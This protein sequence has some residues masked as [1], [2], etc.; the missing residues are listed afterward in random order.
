MQSSA[1]QLVQALR[2]ALKDNDRLRREHRELA[3][4]VREPI[5]VV[6]MACRYPGGVTSPAELWQLVGRGGD[7]ITPFPR[8]RGWSLDELRGAG[9]D[10]AGTSYVQRGGFLHDAADFDAE[11]FGISPREALAMDPQQRLLLETSWEA[12]ERAGIDPASLRGS[13]VGVFSGM[14]GQGYAWRLS[15]IPPEVEGYVGTGNTAS[16]ASGR[17][18]YAFG[19]EGPAITIDTACS[20]SLVAVHLAAHA[21]RH[22]ECSMALAGGATVMSTPD[23]FVEFSRQR[24]LAP[25]GRCKAFSADADGTGWGEGVGVLLLEKLSDARRLGHPVLAVIRGSAVN[26]DGASNGLTAPSGPAQEAVIRQALT[27]AGLTAA[28]VDAVEAHGTGTRLGDLI[29]A[30]SLLATYGT[31]RPEGDPV[32]IGS[33]KSNI[34]HTQAAAGVGGVIKMIM[35]MRHRTLPRTLHVET[36]TT[37][38]DWSSGTMA[39]LTEQLPWPERDRPARAAVSSF[40]VSGTNAHVILEAPGVSDETPSGDGAGSTDRA[41]ATGVTAASA[42]APRPWLLAARTPAALREQAQRLYDFVSARPELRDADIELSL[43]T[44]RTPF[45]LRAVI[46]GDDRET[47]AGALAAL[48]RDERSPHVVTGRAVRGDAVFV[49]PGQGSQWL[50]MG[51]DLYETYPV[52]AEHLRACEEALDPYVDWSLLS[53]LRGV[54]DAPSLD[55]VDVVQPALFAVMVSLAHLWRS[56]GVRPAAVIGHS[57]GEI[58]AAYVAGA[59][60]LEDAARIVALRSRALRGLSGQGA[61]AVVSMSADEVARRIENGGRT[62]NGDGGLSVAAVNGPA[63]TVV[64]GAPG[65]VDS[66]LDQAAAE[67]FQTRR[68]PVDY[69]SHSAQMKEI[70]QDLLD[71]LADVTAR[72]GTTRFY[73]TVTADVMDTAGLHAA[74][75]YRNL[76]Q[77]VRFEETVRLLLDHDHRQFVEC[78]PH[79]A[80][81]AAVADTAAAADVPA[82]AVGSLRRDDGSRRRFLTSLAEAHAHGVTVDW[83]ALPGTDGDRVELPTYAFERRR[84]WLTSTPGGSHGLTAAGLHSAEHPLLGAAVTVAAA[85]GGLL[86]TGRLGLDSHPWLADHRILDAVLVPGTAL[87]EVATHAARLT[88]AGGVAELTLESPLIVPDEGAVEVQVLVEEPD[89]D[90]RRPLTIHSRAGD[91]PDTPDSLESSDSPNEAAWHRHARG[92]LTTDTDTDTETDAPAPLAPSAAWPPPGATPVPTDGLYNHLADADFQYGDSFRGLRAAW[93][94]G[95]DLLAEVQLPT[96]QETEAGRFGLHPALLDS[97]LHALGLGP[98]AD[99]EGD[100][101]RL[102]FSWSNVQLHRPGTDRLRVRISPVE[103]TD[104][105]SL[106]A[107]DATG[108][109]VLTVGSLALRPVSPEL[110]RTATASRTSDGL[111]CRVEWPIRP[112]PST[113]SA[114]GRT[115]VLGDDLPGWPTADRL[116]GLL[117]NFEEG[118]LWETLPDPVPTDVV[119]VYAPVP[120]EPDGDAA[121]AARAAVARTLRLVQDWI[122]DERLAESRLVLVTRGAVEVLPGE[123]VTDLAHAAMWGLVR[124]AQ[125]EHPGRFALLDIDDTDIV[126]DLLR[127]ALATGENQLAVRGGSLH[128]PTLTR[129]PADTAAPTEDRPIGSGGTVLV[130]G[131]TGVLG[132]LVAEWLVSVC[133]VRHLVLVGRRGMSEG[134]AERVGRLVGL[135]AGVRVVAADVSS[136]AGVEEALAAVDAGRPL[137]GV[138][139]AAGVVDDGVVGSLSS[140][141]VGA[142]MG[143]KAGGAWW[144]HMLT[145]GMDLSFFVVFSSVAGVVGSPGQANYAAA[146]G[147]LDGLMQQRRACGLVGQSV[148]WGLWDVSG[149]MAGGLGESDLARMS[150]GGITGLSASEGLGLLR[151]AWRLPDSLLVAARWDMTVWRDAEIVPTMLRGLVRRGRG[152]PRSRRPATDG[153]AERLTG[154]SGSQLAKAVVEAVRAEVASV[155]GFASVVDVPVGLAFREM[156]FDSLTA[157]ELR[158]RLSVLLGV[159]LSATVVFDY[160]SVGALA[161]FVC[162]LVRAEGGVGGVVSGAGAGLVSVADAD[163]PVVIVGVGCRYPG[164]VV[165]GEG[166][167]GLVVSGGDAVGGFPVDRGWDLGV[168]EG[169]GDV[170]PRGGGFV[171]GAA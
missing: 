147:F 79:P 100:S 123:G 110:V 26:Q 152:A 166:L 154:L 76:R 83:A 163:D 30:Q 87:L 121:E 65:T 21:L 22:G 57:Q 160:P 48:A 28:D 145:R 113:P 93:R 120:A 9:A 51:L 40:G 29:E 78:S 161:E 106:H 146:N 4:A 118:A 131:G 42:D 46:V 128:T 169:V 61:M 132:G 136:R 60:S 74:Y 109:P 117:G 84:H 70:Q 155:L 75:W 158:N 14:M 130:T 45:D 37:A 25:D 137:A 94:H 44:G 115:V 149:G 139:H 54:P 6:G 15:D 69:A 151:T 159:R 111:L 134:V 98:F 157:V 126:A 31:G 168:L 105:V 90:G 119:L 95:Q 97:A 167:W 153:L 41:G 35:A 165:S 43:R 101:G 58:A 55:R 86:L 16:V 140:E 8:D 38:I 68:L 62:G 135:G 80:L 24:G 150:R 36:A 99:E 7:A 108:V 125:S 133:G 164:G 19:L 127:A 171:H 107:T 53:V 59:L 77:T 10:E 18:A 71:T 91:A 3:T 82:A 5:A 96:G 72:P 49:F 73:S 143:G 66:F 104:T 103:G 156:G 162:G 50:G 67:G 20:S 88:G 89:D 56:L 141:Q 2:A 12:V 102:P 11:F 144:L 32:R 64:A 81:L 142:V 33:L 124:S 39:L 47:R 1:D 17:V 63:S 23:T 138:V 114:H 85:A 170:V 13:K 52:F 129:V 148:A 122:G 112:R 34:G 116:P 27:T 92:F